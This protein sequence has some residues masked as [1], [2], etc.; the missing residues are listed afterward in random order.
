MNAYTWDARDYEK[1][2]SAQQSWGKALIVKLRLKGHEHVLDLG[3]G[4]GKLTVEIARH[5]PNGSVVG[6]DNSRSMIELARSR[7]PEADFPNLHFVEQDARE[8]S[9]QNRFDAVFSNAALHW[10]KDHKPVL[11]GICQALR[12][13]GRFLLQ[14]GG[15]GNA[16]EIL[17]VLGEMMESDGWAK[18]FDGFEFPYGFYG[19]EEYEK[20]LSEA[21]LTPERVELV[22]K[23]MVQDGPAGLAGWIRTT[24]LPYTERVPESMRE[25]FIRELVERYLRTHPA[26]ASGTVHVKM[27][28]LEVEAKKPEGN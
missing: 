1:S 24:W 7:Y 17:A 5:V 10:V 11:V 15:R 28:R 4:D 3:C 2:S 8:L 9:Y 22:E 21:G 26:D 18:Y 12:P 6:A 13:G 27:V 25:A 19:P 20:W 16:S 14:M 23:D